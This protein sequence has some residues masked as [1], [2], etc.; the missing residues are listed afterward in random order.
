MAILGV[1]RGV[2]AYPHFQTHPEKQTAGDPPGLLLSED[3]CNG[4]AVNLLAS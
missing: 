4:A 1:Y 3:G 2:S